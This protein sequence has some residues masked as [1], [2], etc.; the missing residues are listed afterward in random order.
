MCFSASPRIVS[1]F[2]QH[3]LLLTMLVTAERSMAQEQRTFKEQPAIQ[4]NAATSRTW[5]DSS[6]QYSVE[7]ALVAVTGQGVQLKKTDDT[8]LAVAF[9]RLS[10]NDRTYLNSLKNASA[11]QPAQGAWISNLSASV[12]SGMTWVKVI[13]D[14]VRHSV[15]KLDATNLLPA[16]PLPADMIYIQLSKSLAEQVFDRPV[17]KHSVVRD[18]IVGSP[19]SGRAFTQGRTSVQLVPSRDRA[20][21]D[22][23]FA[24]HV[25]SNTTADGGRVQVHSQG[26]TDFSTLK[27]IVLDGQGLHALPA[28]TNASTTI[29]TSGLS[30]E[31]PRLRGR[32]AR[33]IASDRI[34]ETRGQAQSESARSAERRISR[35]FDDEV[36]RNLDEAGTK[37]AKFLAQIPAAELAEVTPHFSSSG[38]YLQVAFVRGG[39]GELATTLP[40]AP[41]ALGTPDVAVHVHA[42]VVQRVVADPELRKAVQ[43]FV[44]MFMTDRMRG[45]IGDVGP[46]T[47]E[48][49]ELQQSQDGIW[50]SV[51]VR[52]AKLPPR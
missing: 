37:L 18:T 43:P 26:R 8:Q 3:S 33:R 6:G 9:D 27:R 10:E 21:L 11:S 2:M 20:V 15:A 34:A 5:T 7:A 13:P 44:Q 1:K 22:L 4:A 48:P 40:P 39:N 16:G 23:F 29:A 31:L 49:F 25:N 14:R 32:I 47:E 35:E 19:V 51:V 42:A 36:H 41:A 46:S 38:S 24:G 45:L 50:W 52:S 28:A 12:R 30:T 17:A